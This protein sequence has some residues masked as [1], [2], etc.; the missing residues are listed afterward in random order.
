M[1]VIQLKRKLNDRKDRIDLS[2][3][4]ECDA[5]TDDLSALFSN[6]DDDVL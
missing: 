6:D 1:D 5:N 4:S 2:V 3:I